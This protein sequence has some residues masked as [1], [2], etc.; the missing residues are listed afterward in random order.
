MNK[1]IR[2]A[3]V[4]FSIACFSISSSVASPRSNRA[5][6][7]GLFQRWFGPRKGVGPKGSNYL[8]N[9]SM[10]TYK[11][12]PSE[13]DSKY[14]YFYTGGHIGV[15]NMYSDLS[16]SPNILS[17]DLG[18]TRL[19]FGG[20][21]GLRCDSRL[22]FR[23]S[24]SWMRL[25]ADDYY[26]NLSSQYGPE[27]YARN[28]SVRNDLVE[29]GIV[30]VVDLIGNRGSYKMRAD[31]TPYFFGGINVFYHNP[32]AMGPKGSDSEGTWVSL[33]PLGTEG[34]G[35]PGYSKPYSLIQVGFPVGVGIRHQ[36]TERLDISFEI[37]WR[38]TTTNYLDDVGAKYYADP[39]VFGTNQ[40]ARLMA[41]RSQETVA[42]AVDQG[43]DMNL[44]NKITGGDGYA[45]P[46]VKEIRG[47]GGDN[48]IYVLTGFK[49]N[50]IIPTKIF[51][52]KGNHKW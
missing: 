8:R 17:T 18:F 3:L 5:A 28:L 44:V 38:I 43:R 33:Q 10:T 1:G 15:T 35:R 48:D 36:L 32:K 25:R 23:A 45:K 21:F 26:Q 22:S 4:M 39:Q 19:G 50:Y 30:G 51:A 52:K 40:L 41:D 7:K 6:K 20:E 27:R 29:F 42:A 49:L 14:N 11:G 46:G 16:P 13:Y 34:Q 47:S 2:I 12:G 9:R 24:L 37:G 31:Y